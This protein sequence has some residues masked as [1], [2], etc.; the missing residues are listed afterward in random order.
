METE[1][2]EGRLAIPAL[3]P[4]EAQKGGRRNH[5]GPRPDREAAQPGESGREAHALAAVSAGVRRSTPI[6]VPRR[7][8]SSTDSRVFSAFSSV[9]HA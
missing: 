8:A 4:P 5:V 2:R 6:P 3:P 1:R 7:S 9:F